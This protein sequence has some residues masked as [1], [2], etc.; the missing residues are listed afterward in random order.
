VKYPDI[1]NA[2]VARKTDNIAA[3]EADVVLAGDLGCLMN[4][5][6]K[7]TRQGRR[8]AARHVAEV[9]AGETA[10]PPIGQGP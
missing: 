8:I 9:L 6:G 7:L 1:S 2:I 3:T 4:M 10:D 5:A